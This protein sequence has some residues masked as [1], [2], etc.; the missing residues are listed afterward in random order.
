VNA[1][2][3]A[4]S[5]DGQS[6]AAEI[7]LNLYDYT[8]AV[9]GTPWG[10][11]FGCVWEPVFHPVRGTVVAPVRIQGQW[12]LAQDGQVIWEKRF[13]QLWHTTF[14]P[15]GKRLAAIVAPRFGRWT[16]AVD[17]IPWSATVDEMATDAVFSPDGTRIAVTVKD[18]GRWSLA[19]DGRI[20]QNTFDMAWQPVFSP[21]GRHLAA[22]IQRNGKYSVAVDDRPWAQDCEMAWDPVFSPE[23]DQLLLRTI[24]G[25]IYFRRVMPVADITG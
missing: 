1:W 14:A 9:N 21:D 10:Q 15:D 8:I 16:V 3:T 4:F 2:K 19:A 13:V 22:R 5:P 7:R 25:G 18:R 6:L 11:T 23:G 20:W 24:E 12:T 17:G